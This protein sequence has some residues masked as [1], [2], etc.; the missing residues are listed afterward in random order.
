MK[1][2]VII[3]AYNEEGGIVKTVTDVVENAKDFDYVVINDCSKD[4]TL[5]ICR[6]HN[7]NV[8]NL[9][10]NMGIGGG[11]QTGYMYAYRNGYDIA[12][13]FDGDGQHNASYLTEMSE[14][15]VKEQLDMVIG[16]R[17]IEKEGFQ[18]SGMRRLGIRYFT[19]LIKLLTGKKITDPTSGMRM[20]NRKIMKQFSEEYPKDYPEPESVVTILKEG[21]KVEEIPVKMN[22]RE[23]GV[24]SISPSKS[25]YY[26]VKVSIAV[27]IAA[28][29]K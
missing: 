21:A 7:F 9:P 4:N 26:M 16:S 22:A 14:K 18:S 12:V 8:V 11:V 20:I 6:E 24:S 13:Q 15:L 2:L 28:I 17:Y 25:I 19:G 5:K 29:R 27:L 23:E 10:V 3:P 1:K